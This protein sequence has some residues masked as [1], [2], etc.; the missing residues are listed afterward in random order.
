[1]DD[2]KSDSKE[3]RGRGA[4]AAVS[5][6]IVAK[7]RPADNEAQQSE[8]RPHNKQTC[9]ARGAEGARHSI[10]RKSGGDITRT[11][12]QPLSRCGCTVRLSV[13]GSP[14]SEFA[15]LYGKSRVHSEADRVRSG[16]VL[17]PRVVSPSAASAGAA[18]AAPPSRP[19]SSRTA[20][21]FLPDDEIVSHWIFR[22]LLWLVEWVVKP[23]NGF[24]VS[25]TPRLDADQ[26]GNS[27]QAIQ[28]ENSRHQSLLVCVCVCVC[29]GAR[30]E[31]TSEA[32]CQHPGHSFLRSPFH[33]Q[34]GDS[35]FSG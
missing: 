33:Q 7:Q 31:A 29:V 13:Q 26:R 11:T 20:H 15:S 8:R 14:T 4:S 21:A 5:P 16:G 10:A 32:R 9:T 30:S 34:L 19:M 28:L 1:M 35:H 25:R 24:E 2:T 22:L 27:R 17:Q 23:F 3:R 6:L 18:A 12:V